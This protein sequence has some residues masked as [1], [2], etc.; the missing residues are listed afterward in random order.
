[1]SFPGSLTFGRLMLVCL[2][3]A[4]SC[5]PA[6]AGDLRF[7]VKTFHIQGDNPLPASLTARLLAPYRGWHSG[8]APLEEAAN[9]L[10]DAMADR[11]FA[12]N[13]VIV[14]P[15]KLAGET[16]TLKI[17]T[18]P[19]GKLSVAGNHH[20]SRENI[21]RSL[22]PLEKNKTPN[23]HAVARALQVANTHPVK[24]VAVFVKQNK[25]SGCIDTRVEARDARPWQVFG[26][27]ANTG[28]ADTGRN[29]V[30]VGA[31]HTN[32]FD[33]DHMATLSYSTS[34]EN[35][36]TV[37]QF[38]AY[39]QLPIYTLATKVSA[40]FISS[41]I[42]QGEVAGVFDVSGRGQ[43]AGVG[44]DHTLMPAGPYNH[45]LHLGIQDRFFDNRTTWNNVPLPGDVRSVPVT[46]GYSGELEKA[47]GALRF[48]MD[49]V[50]NSA[51]GSHN[52]DPSYNAARP[53]AKAQWQAGRGHLDL[54]LNLPRNFRLEARL[55]GQYTQRAL[56]P[57]E[58]FGIGGVRS[59]R[60]FRER[61]VYGENGYKLNLELVSPPL[62]YNTQLLIFADTGAVTR[63]D[64]VP[65]T[66][67]KDSLTGAG[68]G[69]RWTWKQNLYASL[70]LAQALK[71][72]MTTRSGDLRAHYQVFI[73]Y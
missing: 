24:Q 33:R 32:L 69:L 10:Q 4:G 34:P 73:R 5:C 43:F 41:Q 39:Y 2:L 61:E 25:E 55:G 20:F 11:G 68:F 70:D 52:N 13:R 71:N 54:R 36:D 14:P 47:A 30:S 38:G 53:G 21:L 17:V 50:H 64:P 29:R 26:S 63:E 18:V 44:L 51:T 40:F 16:V 72:G 35:V 45:A 62:V 59:V 37:S 31:Q 8:L 3:L 46:A 15:Q 42:D 28:D 19:P 56:I 27:L 1:M 58:Q 66:G 7:L 23:T 67:M 9:A 57:G 65:S 6:V 60:G 12:F 48:R 22:P 49:Y